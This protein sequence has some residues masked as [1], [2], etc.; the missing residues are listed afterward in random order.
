MGGGWGMGSN[1][2]EETAF[3]ACSRSGR[4]SSA[5]DGIVIMSGTCGGSQVSREISHIRREP[6]DQLKRCSGAIMYGGLWRE[7]LQNAGLPF[8][9]FE[10]LLCIRETDPEHYFHRSPLRCPQSGLV[11]KPH[12]SIFPHLHTIPSF[13]F[14]FNL[15]SL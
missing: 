13:S 9:Q 1:R 15:T 11:P 14:G 10:T 4:A 8:F 3:G 2:L 12:T 5:W 7:R 6:R